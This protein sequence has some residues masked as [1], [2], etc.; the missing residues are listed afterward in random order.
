MLILLGFLGYNVYKIFV[1]T[2]ADPVLP[3]LA[4]KVPEA[5]LPEPR[6]AEAP[7]QYATFVRRN[8]FS[9]YSDAETD[10]GVS[11]TAEE[12]GIQLIAIKEGIGGKWRARLKTKTAKWYDEGDS[13]EEFRLEEINHVEQK[14]VV[15]ANRFA[16]TV[17]LNVEN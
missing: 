14:V 7:G 17:V 2:I 10:G 5:K 15:Y 6:M 4:G 8:P 9:Y 12:A 13:F 3:P 1:P 11:L 16:K